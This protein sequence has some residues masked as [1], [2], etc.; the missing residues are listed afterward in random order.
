[1]KHGVVCMGNTLEYKN[2]R[3]EFRDCIEGMKEL[4]DKSVDLCL[5][6]PPYNI[7]WGHPKGKSVNEKTNFDDSIDNYPTFCFNWM[8]EVNRIC[9]DV[10]FFPGRNNLSIWY[11]LDDYDLAIWH[12]PIKQGSSK[13]AKLNKIEPILTN[14][15]SK[16]RLRCNYLY[17]ETDQ[18]RGFWNPKHF[19]F[20]ETIHPT[21]KPYSLIFNI[22][23]ELQPSS[24]L[25]P[26][27]GSGTTLEACIQLGI[28]CIGYE[29]ME[30]YRVDMEK[31]IK[32]SKYYRKPKQLD[33]WMHG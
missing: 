10:V 27:M 18:R 26:F 16:K 25:D 8:R 24:V 17:A 21:P 12:N 23:N 3:V 7:K 19:D 11:R 9:E 4:E 22:I 20:I 5:T 31:R 29:L 30:E 28:P 6:D 1:M 15:D 2:C 13:C 14:L 32:R 33:V